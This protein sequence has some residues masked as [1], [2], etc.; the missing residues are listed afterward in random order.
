MRTNTLIGLALLALLPLWVEG[1][2]AAQDVDQEYADRVV[3]LDDDGAK[4][5]SRNVKVELATYE[6]AG[7]KY[8]QRGGR[9]KSE[10]NGSR[11]LMILYG[12]APRVFMDGEQNLLRGLY[13]KAASDFDGAKNAVD[14]GKCRP[15]LLEIA[16]VRRGQ[17]LT[18]MGRKEKGRLPD[19]IKEFKAALT[20]NPKSL[21]FD[22]I[23]LGLVEAHSLQGKWSDAQAAAQNLL[24]VGKI[25]K[26]P[27]WQAQAQ[28]AV[29][30]VLL[31]QK[32]FAE[33]VSAYGDLSSLAAREGKYVKN[34][35]R[36]AALAKYEVSGAVEQG[37]ALIAAAEVTGGWDKAK[38]H[39]Q[40]LE[41]KFP[42]NETVAAA[43]L[44]GVGRTL[45]KSDPRAAY[46][47]FCKAQVTQ[48]NARTEVA[49]ALYLKSQAL[50]AMGGA[51]N[52]QR[53]E[54]ALK[55]LRKFYP[56]TPFARN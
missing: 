15:W 54:E 40:A 37:W 25:I 56:E 53:A 12:D 18:A 46:M 31:Q 14:A 50:K 2:V 16:A 29:A 45:M 7:V 35:L 6:D 33:A 39:F 8:L 32:K 19:A 34:A 5:D 23:Q 38:S 3:Y 17:A 11:I 28:Q 44:N 55:E 10:R 41:G 21:L 20:A 9:S 48:F 51:T 1:P 43:V 22:E 49:R 36:K 24:N 30:Q 27:V 13:E 26:Q 52:N 42:G 47:M 4:Q